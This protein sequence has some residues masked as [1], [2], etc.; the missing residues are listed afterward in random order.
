[1]DVRE[2]AKQF[3]RSVD[4]TKLPLCALSHYLQFVDCDIYK[5]RFCIFM[6]DEITLTHFLPQFPSNKIG[7]TAVIVTIF[8]IMLKLFVNG[9][10]EQRVSFFLLT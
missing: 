10:D 7:I 9:K 2:N 6:A 8:S 3:S 4:D 1:M 5:G